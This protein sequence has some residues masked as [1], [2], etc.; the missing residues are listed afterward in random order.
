[1]GTD[2][3]DFRLAVAKNRGL[4]EFL[5]LLLS[6][7]LLFALP[8]ILG[9]IAVLAKTLGV[10]EFLHMHTCPSLF[11]AAAAVVAVNAHAFG[12]VT[13][14]FVRTRDDLQRIAVISFL[15]IFS[16]ALLLIGANVDML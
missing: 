8:I 6:L 4:D 14:R 13:S 3:R 12:V 9:Q 1:M 7:L 10:V 16:I 15:L 5:L 2:F 11:G